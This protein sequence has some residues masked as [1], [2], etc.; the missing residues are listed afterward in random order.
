MPGSQSVTVI[1]PAYNRRHLI[2]RSLDSVLTQTHPAN[3]I[4]VVD[5]GSTDDTKSL[6][7]D[8]YPGVNYIY[9]D[10]RGVSAARNTG[11]DKA[12]SEWLAFLDSDDEWLPRKLEL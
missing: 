11:I 9:Q 7:L 2:S 12:K 1:I 5:D 10:N 8:R 3:E 4:I 6:V